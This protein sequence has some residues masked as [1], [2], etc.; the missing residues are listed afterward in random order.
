LTA[1][2]ARGDRALWAVLAIWAAALVWSGVGP[3]DRLTWLM[4]VAPVLIAAPVMLATRR[5]FPLT[6]M[7]LVLACLHGL[8]LI[9]GGH[10]TY[11]EVPVG[12]WV[13]DLFGFSRNHYDRLGHFAQGFVPAILAREI[14]LRRT[15]LRP[16]GMLVLLA[17]SVCLAFSALYELIEWCAA[18]IL[19][20]GA[21][22][23]MGMQGDQWDTQADM[24]LALV[25]ALLALALLS[26]AHDRALAA[27]PR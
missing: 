9:V 12:F 24:A 6:G 2:A 27:L 10:Y 7:L 17:T 18:L 15:E 23:F 8:I 19:G 3:K 26:K 13:Q 1:K 25:G 14:L 16:G 20:Q 21:D 5:A 4:E 11:A 22:A